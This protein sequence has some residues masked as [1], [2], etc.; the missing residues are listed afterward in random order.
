MSTELLLPQTGRKTDRRL[1]LHNVSFYVPVDKFRGRSSD[2]VMIASLPVRFKSF[3]TNEVH[4]T[5]RS[6]GAA[7]RK[8]ISK[9][10]TPWTKTKFIFY[11][12]SKINYA[13]RMKKGAVTCWR[14][15]WH[16]DIFYEGHSGTGTCFMRDTVA[17]G[18]VL[19]GTQL[20][21]DM[22]YEGHSG[23]G[24]WF[25]RDTVAL[26]YVLRGTLWHWVMF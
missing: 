3:F 16:W 22:F 18:H 21:W 1:L 7:F 20:H 14:T 26:G 19:W 25:M 2:Y 4:P 11:Y 17:L 9:L 12:E 5:I 10:V 8:I 24:I 6:H 23:T 15:Q 13:D